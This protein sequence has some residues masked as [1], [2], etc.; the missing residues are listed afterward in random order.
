MAG[1]VGRLHGALRVGALLL[2]AVHEGE[3]RGTE[4]LR[5]SCWAE[6]REGCSANW[7]RLKTQLALCEQH[8]LLL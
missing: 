5:R 4:V 2:Q 7:G 3:L 6:K 1:G 8:L